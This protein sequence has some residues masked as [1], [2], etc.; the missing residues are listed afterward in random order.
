LVKEEEK[1]CIL[2]AGVVVAPLFIE[3][4]DI[5]YHVASEEVHD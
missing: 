3:E 4:R 5:V 2:N 1:H